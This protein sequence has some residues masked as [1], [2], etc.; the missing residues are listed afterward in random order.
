MNYSTAVIRFFGVLAGIVL[1]LLVV[2]WFLQSNSGGVAPL[3]LLLGLGT[4]FFALVNPRAGLYV[5]AV[6]VIYLDYIKKLAVYFG[7]VSHEAIIQVLIVNMACIG[8]VYIGLI[9]RASVGK[10]VLQTKDYMIF[11]GMIL[12]SLVAFVVSFAQM[13]SVA[14]A[15][16]MAVNL[17]IYGGLLV[18]IPILFRNVGELEKYIK[19]VLICFIPWV[20]LGLKQYFFGYDQMEWFYAETFLS[21]VA[22]NQFFADIAMYGAPRPIGFGSGSVNYGVLGLLIPTSLWF[23]FNATRQTRLRWIIISMLLCAG[24]VASM[25]RA[26]MLLPFIALGFYFFT[27]T[28]TRVLVGYLMGFTVIGLGI[29]FAEYLLAQI[30]HVNALIA[31]ESRWGNTVLRLSTFSDRLYGWQRLTETASYSLFGRFGDGTINDFR[32]GEDGYHDVVNLI[33]D[34]FGI[35]GLAL[36]LTASISFAVW[37]HRLIFSIQNARDRSLANMLIAATVPI[38]VS[39]MLGGANFHTNPFN[40]IMWLHIGGIYCIIKFDTANR[41]TDSESALDSHEEISLHDHGTPGALATRRQ[42]LQA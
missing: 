34:A 1:P 7:E 4:S 25:Q 39:G 42:R 17:T 31:S 14:H 30:E 37:I 3:V 13:K 35:V 21:P 20:F 33:L 41:T 2:P 26:S 29:F 32:G 22:S 19:F 40:F 36:V 18:A 10:I 12:L 9:V 8:F 23:T 24:T 5:A 16:Q 27:K 38:F 28:R 6:Q 11:G 15:G